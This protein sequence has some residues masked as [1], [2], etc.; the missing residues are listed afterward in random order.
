MIKMGIFGIL[1][2]RK[3]NG[4]LLND[5]VYVFFDNPYISVYLIFVF[6]KE[7]SNNNQ[8]TRLL[9]RA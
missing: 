1:R 8:S 7:S 6:I 9:G 3:F 2:I 4:E 5:D